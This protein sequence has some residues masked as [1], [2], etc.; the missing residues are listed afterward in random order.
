MSAVCADAYSNQQA[1]SDRFA[2]MASRIRRHWHRQQPTYSVI[3]NRSPSETAA[4]LR[5]AVLDFFAAS[6]VQIE[7]GEMDE[8]TL[9]DSNY[10]D[11]GG[12]LS[13]E[14]YD[15]LTDFLTGIID[16]N[17]SKI[18]Q[19]EITTIKQTSKHL[20]EVF[21]GWLELNGGDPEEYVESGLLSLICDEMESKSERLANKGKDKIKFKL[22]EE[23]LGLLD[24]YFE[25]E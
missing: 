18:N 10:I 15:E 8:Y 13:D 7:E 24:E 23:L 4:M 14:F 20:L 17:D 25:E 1:L 2:A 11:A 3:H 5:R 9:E 21:S 12:N 22:S 6:R 19:E 16:R